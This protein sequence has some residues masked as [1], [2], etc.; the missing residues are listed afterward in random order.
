MQ[1]LIRILFSPMVFA[2]GFLWPLITQAGQAAG[3]LDP[4]WQAIVVGALVAIPWGVMAQLRG[5]WMW[6]R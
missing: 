6:V 1:P 4:G 3:L 2:I 5:S